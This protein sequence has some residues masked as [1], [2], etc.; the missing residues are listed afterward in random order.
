MQFRLTQDVVIGA[1]G[2][3]DQNMEDPSTYYKVS[4][5]KLL[6]ENKRIKES[7]EIHNINLLLLNKHQYNEALI[8]KFIQT[9]LR[10]FDWFDEKVKEIHSNLPFTDEEILIF[11]IIYNIYF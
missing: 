5:N 2:I 4:L 3:E 1:G 10:P 7:K 8:E 11:Y 9:L 6:E